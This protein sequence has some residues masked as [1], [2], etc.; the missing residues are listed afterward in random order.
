MTLFIP[1]DKE[2]KRQL[3][4]LGKMAGSVVAYSFVLRIENR[5]SQISHSTKPQ[6]STENFK[7]KKHKNNLVILT[8]D[9]KWFINQFC[10]I[11]IL[12]FKLIWQQTET[13]A[14]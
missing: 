7:P 13:Q 3:T 5:R 6:T 14:K 1:H 11:D 8:I 12:K 4:A 10:P 2:V 9:L